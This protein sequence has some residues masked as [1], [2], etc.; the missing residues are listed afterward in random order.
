MTPSPQFV[1]SGQHTRYCRKEADSSTERG[2]PEKRGRRR[3]V[4][5][6][7]QDIGSTPEIRN[8]VLE[9]TSS[10]GKNPGDWIQDCTDRRERR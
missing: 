5:P 7:E 4:A 3:P 6:L 10:E 8:F 9:K 1:C 2:Q